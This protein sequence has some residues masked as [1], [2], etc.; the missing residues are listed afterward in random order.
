MTWL[1]LL[2]DVIL[3]VLL[4]DSC[5]VH[6][7][8]LLLLCVVAV[9]YCCSLFVV[10]ERCGLSLFV[11]VV[12]YRCGVLRLCVATIVVV[13]LWLIWVG[14]VG[15]CWLLLLVVLMWCVLSFAVRC[16]RSLLVVCWLL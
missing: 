3:G 7:D 11:G 16:D 4:M 10:V 9:C 5:V 15:G 2:V 13:C 12:C 1:W 8:L 14:V 6:C